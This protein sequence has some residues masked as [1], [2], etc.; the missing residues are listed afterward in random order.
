MR[1]TRHIKRRHTGLAVIE[2]GLCEQGSVITPAVKAVLQQDGEEVHLASVGEDDELYAIEIIT[3]D[4][5][6]MHV[7]RREAELAS[8]WKD[9]SKEDLPTLPFQAT[10]PKRGVKGKT[11][12]AIHYQGTAAFPAK[13]HFKPMEAEEV[14]S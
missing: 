4:E 8:I 5:Y 14:S 11:S 3:P 13:L 12:Y 1:Y 6:S 9:F 7:L 10:D 2:T